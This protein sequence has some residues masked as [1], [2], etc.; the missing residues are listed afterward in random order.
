MNLI[1]ILASVCGSLLLAAACLKTI[2]TGPTIGPPLSPAARLVV[3][4][5]VF[6]AVIS[7][8][9]AL[10]WRHPMR[11]FESMLVFI[12]GAF[13]CWRAWAPWWQNFLSRPSW[14]AFLTVRPKL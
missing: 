4:A 12:L 5:L 6:L 9:E 3:F 11:P 2:E 14:P 10:A 7:A 1:L 13:S 8:I